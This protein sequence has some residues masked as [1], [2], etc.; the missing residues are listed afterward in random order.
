MVSVGVLAVLRDRSL[1]ENV[2]DRLRDSTPPPQN[3]GEA[4]AYACG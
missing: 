1:H 2:E 4:D 3:R